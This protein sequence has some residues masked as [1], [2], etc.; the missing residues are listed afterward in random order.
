VKPR[1]VKKLDPATPLR[2]NAERIMRTR[3]DELRSLAEPALDPS[4][5]DAQHDLRIACKRLRYVLE[6]VGSCFGEESEAAR[7]VARELQTVL[8][9][10]HDCDVMLPRAEGIDS[11]TVF[12]RTRR[13][14]LFRRFIDLWRAKKTEATLEALEWALQV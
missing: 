2:V 8:G 7:D 10:I 4:A 14:L 9:E 13:E 3:L 5:A 1:R 12:L 11:L 6:L